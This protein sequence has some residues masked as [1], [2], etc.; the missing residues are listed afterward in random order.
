MINPCG[1]DKA[2][3]L[4]DNRT[5]GLEVLEIQV[6]GRRVFKVAKA[7]NAS[8]RAC[9]ASSGQ[10]RQEDGTHVWNTHLRLGKREGRREEAVNQSVGTRPGV[11][12]FPR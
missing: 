11:A 12:A 3:I 4:D 10:G 2:E 9:T 1:H 7:S 8:A 6:A 5:A